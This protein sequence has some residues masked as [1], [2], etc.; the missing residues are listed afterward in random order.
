MVLFYR[1]VIPRDLLCF[2]SV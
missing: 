1:F 2:Y